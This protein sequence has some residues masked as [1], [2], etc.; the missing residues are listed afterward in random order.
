MTLDEFSAKARETLT[1]L[2]S[3][4][5]IGGI[6]DELIAAYRERDAAAASAETNVTELTR[7]N[8]LLQKANMELYLRTGTK[9]EKTDDLDGVEEKKGEDFS[10]LFDENGELK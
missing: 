5:E 2:E 6:V 9:A 8:E 1:K 3:P 4:E 10:M 7:K